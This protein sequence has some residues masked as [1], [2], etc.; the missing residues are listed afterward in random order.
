MRGGARFLALSLA[1]ILIM[2]SGA[3][4]ADE[5]RK[6]YG[7]VREAASPGADVAVIYYDEKAGGHV[8]AEFVIDPDVRLV[9]IPTA[10]SLS[11]GDWVMIDYVII[12]G[13]K[14]ARKISA[15]VD[16]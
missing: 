15:D 7:K 11:E 13:K 8:V 16:F 10:K 14:M 9:N 5:C 1:L 6:I 3:F 2:R 4:A 12:A